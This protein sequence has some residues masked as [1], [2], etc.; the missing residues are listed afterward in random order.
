VNLYLWRL[1]RS[2]NEAAAGTELIDQEGVLY[3]RGPK[4]RMELGYLVTTWA[5]DARN[6]HQL[7]GRVLNAFLSTHEIDERFLQGALADVR[8]LP[9]LS[10][11]KAD[12]DPPSEFWVALGGRFQPGVELT[13]T[14]TIDPAVL[15]DTAPPPTSVETILTDATEPGRS[16]R[17]RRVAGRV[18]GQVAS[19]TVVRTRRGSTVVDATGAFL[20]PAEAGDE[21]VVDTDPV[22][23]AVVPPAGAVTPT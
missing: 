19:R 9:G 16:S 11:S 10:L 2:V 21:V 7:L 17:R 12:D 20:V 8:P 6:A 15:V 22:R 14:A 4:P 3:R 18:D 5:T 23:R 13:V 1:R